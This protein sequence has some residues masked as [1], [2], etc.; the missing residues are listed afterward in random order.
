MSDI[1]ENPLRAEKRRK[2]H[3]LREKG[4][5][6]F[7]HTYDQTHHA[8]ELHKKYS[9]L[10]AG[11]KVEGEKISIAGRLMTLRDMGKAAFFN[12]QDQSGSIQIYLRI[13]EQNEA[14]QKAFK[15][16]D[17]GDIVGIKGFMFKTQKG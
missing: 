13:Q 1:K 6:P 3:E 5:D 10:N 11:D 7:P 14:D 15:L 16:V 12:V 17:L 2:L 4:I 8:G 9:H